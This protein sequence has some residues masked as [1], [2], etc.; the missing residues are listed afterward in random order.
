MK[1]K[2]GWMRRKEGIG[3]KR[4][5][6][7]GEEDRRGWEENKRKEEKKEDTEEEKGKKEKANERSM[8]AHVGCEGEVSVRLCIELASRPQLDLHWRD[9]AKRIS[10]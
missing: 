7:E 9:Q 6:V 1:G 8:P 2:R 10:L 3:D 5:Q 4:R